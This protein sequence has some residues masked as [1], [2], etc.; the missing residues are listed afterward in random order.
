MIDKSDILITMITQQVANDYIQQ[1]HPAFAGYLHDGEIG[2]RDGLSVIFQLI[3]KGILIPEFEDNNM[4][5]KMIAV[6][7]TRKK[8]EMLFEEKIIS[9]LKKKGDR[10]LTKEIGA[11]LTN[12]EIQTIIH[13]NLKAISDFPIAHKELKFFLKN[14]EV[15]FSINN[16]LI[17]T[18]KK[19]GQFKL[20][21]P[22][23]ILTIFG[24]MTFNL[25][26]SKVFTDHHNNLIS[27]IPG[28]TDKKQELDFFFF[29][30]YIFFLIISTVMIFSFYFSKRQIS[31]NFEKDVV[32]LIR[33]K[34]ESLNQFLKSQ[35]LSPHRLTNEFLPYSISFG[36]DHSWYEDFGLSEEFNPDSTP[37]G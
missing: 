33:E 23:F 32:P 16:T 10:L 27:Q 36:I 13:L 11:M 8:P 28:L 34:F 3:K 19:L 5:K 35:P 1:L 6:R 7:I 25:L 12:G 30:P 31:Y 26:I 14:H 29:L 21:F 9:F 4:N 17:N 15:Q 20:T 22:I 24:M 37:L 18:V 2:L